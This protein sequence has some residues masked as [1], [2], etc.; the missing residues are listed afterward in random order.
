M[1]KKKRSLF[2]SLPLIEADVKFTNFEE[3]LEKLPLGDV[4][5]GFRC[6]GPLPLFVRFFYGHQVIIRRQM[7]QSFLLLTPSVSFECR[8]GGERS[9]AYRC[10]L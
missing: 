9:A 2:S 10:L 6:A 4:L 3:A 1:L 8:V 5:M 7:E